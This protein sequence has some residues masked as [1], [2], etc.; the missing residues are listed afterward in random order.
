MSGPVF[1]I[2]IP[3]YNCASY[4][5]DTVAVITQQCSPD[6]EILLIDDCSDDATW[7]VMQSLAETLPQVIVLRTAENGGPGHARNLGMQHAQGQWLVFIDSDDTPAEGMLSTI[8]QQ[9]SE[10]AVLPDMISFNW[11]YDKKSDATIYGYEGRDDLELLA[12]TSGAELLQAYCRNQIDSSVIYSVF[13]ADW[14]KPL[15]LNFRT[16]LHE[17]VDFMFIAL[18]HAQSHAVIDQPLYLKNNRDFSIVNS[19]T[20]THIY[21]YFAGLERMF[22]ALQQSKFGKQCADAFVEGLINVAASRLVRLQRMD[23]DLVVWQP[24]VAALHEVLEPW[25]RILN[26]RFEQTDGKFRT[27]YQQIVHFFLEQ[28]GTEL[29]ELK[30]FL[31]E[32]Q[33]KSWS[34]FDLHKSVFLAPDEIRTCCKRFFHEGELKGDVVLLKEEAQNAGTVF[35]YEQIKTAKADL[36]REI[37]RDNSDACRGC[38]FLEFK[39]WQGQPLSD[40]IGYLSFEYH[41][42]CNMKCSYCS[43]TYYGGEKVHYDIAALTDSILEHGALD[44]NEYIVWGGG[45]PLLDKQF[46]TILN[47]ISSKVPAVKQRVI[48]N[49]T[50]FSEPLAA[51]MEADKAYIVTSIDAGLED[52]FKQVRHY[53][54]MD[55]IYK[56]L[57]AYAGRAASNVIIKYIFLPENR[58]IEELFAFVELIKD[59]QLQACN[60]QISFDFKEE[61]LPFEDLSAMVLLYSLLT[62]AGVRLIFFD[63]LILQRLQPLSQVDVS[64]LQ[65]HLAEHDLPDVLCKDAVGNEVVVWGTGAQTRL[66]VDKCQ[67]FSERD[68]ACFIDPRPHRIGQSFMGKLIKAPSSLLESDLPVVIAAV[69]SAPQIYSQ[70]QELGLP[71]SRLVRQLVI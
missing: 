35:N 32:I 19:L 51:L 16:G 48:T 66:L 13:R 45:E 6:D 63:D 15:G 41:S 30:Q 43:E 11:S 27:K 57:R 8:K 4:L 7:A 44:N 3:A 29:P 2:I 33:P 22:D 40:G 36:Y 64:T 34:C 54:R 50:R 55:N 49:A 26:D 12:T 71:A 20:A 25:K 1:S 60:F 17:D 53:N 42:V 18:M 38:P 58:S 47:T 10:Q 28:Q 5:A 56:N 37:N 21:G 67:F 9:I 31:D 59:N 70:Y 14:L 68:I 61:Q 69:Q 46:D 62:Q 23:E 65:Q 24:I 39:D 52:T